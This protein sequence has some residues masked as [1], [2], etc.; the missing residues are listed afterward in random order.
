MGVFSGSTEITAANGIYSGSTPVVEVYSGATLVWEQV[1]TSALSSA[2]SVSVQTTFGSWGTVANANDGDFD[3]LIQYASAATPAQNATADF[4][5]PSV[6]ASE[7]VAFRLNCK[8]RGASVGYFATAAAYVS[9]SG[10][11]APPG[12]ISLSAASSASTS[13]NG[14]ILSYDSGLVS[15]DQSGS[16]A[17]GSWT[18]D[19]SDFIGSGAA[20]LDWWGN[21]P[22]IR[23]TT[24]DINGSGRGGSVYEIQLQ[25]KYKPA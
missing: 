9:A 5:F 22:R 3:T 21:G 23:F 15:T 14:S 17:S 7:I 11:H 19:A 20:V 2:D 6:A 10:S 18:L 12:T 16:D 4:T 1:V 8:I 13:A 25:V 24:R